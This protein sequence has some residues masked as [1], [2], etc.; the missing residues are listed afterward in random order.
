MSFTTKYALNSKHGGCLAKLLHAR[1]IPKRTTSLEQIQR[2]VTRNHIWRISI[3][4]LT[5]I[6]CLVTTLPQFVDL[7]PQTLIAQ[8]R[9][10]RPLLLLHYFYNLY[11]LGGAWASYSKISLPLNRSWGIHQTTYKNWAASHLSSMNQ[12]ADEF[13]NQPTGDCTQNPRGSSP[14]RKITGLLW[15]YWNVSSGALSRSSC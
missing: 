10:L 13:E 6:I 11:D 12:T 4:K 9:Y 8:Q 2:P 14:H 3:W 1:G 5:N 15:T 7:E